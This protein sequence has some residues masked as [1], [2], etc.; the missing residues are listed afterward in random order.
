MMPL[1]YQLGIRGFL[2]HFGNIDPAFALN[3]HEIGMSM[4]FEACQKLWL[5][6][7]DLYEYCFTGDWYRAT[8]FGKEM[9]RI[10]G[11][12]MGDYTRLPLQRPTKEEHEQLKKLMKK[13]GLGIG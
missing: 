13:A 1:D 11:L 2:N 12:S 10:S 8:A 6:M 5:R 9:V 3:M 7:I 4:D